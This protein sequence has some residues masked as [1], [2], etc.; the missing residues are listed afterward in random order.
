[1][2]E[3]VQ[4]RCGR[5]LKPRFAC[6]CDRIVP[7][8]AKTRVLILQHPQEDDVVLGTA[9]ILTT[10]L[11]T[12]RIVVGLSWRSFEA[13][14]GNEAVDRARWATVY[15]HK[16]PPEASAG[17][18]FIIMDRHGKLAEADATLDGIVLLDGTWSQA[19]TLWWRNPWLLKLGR[20]ALRPREPSMYGKARKEPRR[21]AVSTLEATADVLD[22]LGEDPM[23]RGELR[24]LMRT[25]V[26]RVRDHDAANQP[27]PPPRSGG[28]KK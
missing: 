27:G 12:A 8:E 1:M 28:I 26:Q 9:R 18:A 15:A 19:K 7:L 13:A 2:S 16:I 3:P 25:M 4:E 21:E 10:A 11:E 17:A 6:V 5:C 24:K 22:A 14:M 23:V 20:I